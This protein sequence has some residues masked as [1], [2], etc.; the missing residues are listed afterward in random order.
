M[1][2]H[3]EGPL[4]TDVIGLEP[5]SETIGFLGSGSAHTQGIQRA[6]LYRLRI[7]L[8]GRGHVDNLLGDKFR[9][10]VFSVSK[11]QI[12]QRALVGADHHFNFIGT[13]GARSNQSVY[14]HR[15]MPTNPER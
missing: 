13:E 8:A 2:R 5:I 12:S 4:R 1:L 9:E 3:R 6:F 15:R 11:S 14:G 10:R 7:A